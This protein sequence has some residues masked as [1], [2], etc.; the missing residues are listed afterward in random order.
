MLSVNLNKILSLNGEYDF[1]YDP[2]ADYG[3]QT[4]ETLGL[5]FSLTLL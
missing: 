5:G 3:W 4:K 1:R 2:A